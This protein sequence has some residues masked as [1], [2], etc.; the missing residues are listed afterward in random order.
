[1]A[2]TL[3]VDISD[4]TFADLTAVITAAQAAGVKPDAQLSLEGSTLHITIDK[5]ESAGHQNLPHHGPR[6]GGDRGPQPAHHDA[7]GPRNSRGSRNPVGPVGEAA[8]KSVVDILTG[9]QEPPRPTGGFGPHTGHS[10]HNGP[11]GHFDVEDD[12]Q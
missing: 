8:I 12:D 9:K 2:L 5:P 10:G 11:F 7:P 4:A 3:S 6:H 1:M